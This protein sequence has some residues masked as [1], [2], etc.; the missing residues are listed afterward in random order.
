M[1]SSIA[2]HL[3]PGLKSVNSYPH[4]GHSLLRA[5]TSMAQDGHSFCFII[6]GFGT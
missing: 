6:S 1:I 5:G 3:Y 2:T 4:I